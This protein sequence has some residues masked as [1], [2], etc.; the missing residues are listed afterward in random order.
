MEKAVNTSLKEAAQLL[1]DESRKEY[2][3]KPRKHG[4]EG[5]KVEKSIQATKT[6]EGMSVGINEKVCPYAIFIHE[7]TKDHWVEPDKKKAL[8]WVDGG[9]SHFSKGHNVSGLEPD[10][11]IY[12]AKE[13]NGPRIKDLVEK[14]VEDAIHKAGF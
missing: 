5:S 7:G 4:P 13:K 6:P 2:L 8:H 3:S 14:N 10:P 9:E 11:F 1:V 12:R